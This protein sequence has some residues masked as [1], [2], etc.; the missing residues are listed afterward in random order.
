MI[1]FLFYHDCTFRM[2]K[3]QLPGEARNFRTT[4]SWEGRRPD[5]QVSQHNQSEDLNSFQITINKNIYQFKIIEIFVPYYRID[6]GI[7][8][9]DGAVRWEDPSADV[10]DNHWVPTTGMYWFHI[11]F[12]YSITPTH[13]FLINML[14]SFTLNS[15]TKMEE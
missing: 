9:N 1:V 15:P 12:Y 14:L 10:D 3:I 7:G 8:N 4:G 5:I 6:N 2:R 11:S 13:I